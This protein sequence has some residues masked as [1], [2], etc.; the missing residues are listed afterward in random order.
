[1]RLLLDI[2]AHGFGHLSQTALI[3]SALRR[4]RPNLSLVVRSGLDPQILAARLGPSIE[5]WPSDTDFG[6]VM[7]GP[8][9]VDR[10][11]TF[12]RY[13]EL[14][15][16]LDRVVDGIAKGLQRH[17]IDAVFS[18][19]SFPVLI[20]ARQCGTPSVACSSLIWSEM[21]EFYFQGIA[22]SKPIVEGMR[23]AY[24]TATGLV[25][26]TPGMPMSGHQPARVQQPIGRRGRNRRGELI[27][28][29]GGDAAT[30]VLLWAFGGMQ[31]N[32]PPYLRAV[33]N[34]LS[35][36][37]SSWGDSVISADGLGWP[38][39]DLIASCD[40]VI[41]KPG[42]GI[43]VELGANAKPN[44]LLS[45]GDWPEEPHLIEWLKKVAPCRLVSSSE[46]VDA[47]SFSQMISEVLAEPTKSPAAVGG[48][49][50][51]VDL[52]RQF[53]AI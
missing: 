2:T 28:R 33:S 37:P 21:A 20:A 25:A 42:Y 1:M 52:C 30:R 15:D 14:F 23:A 40:V 19:I 46:N 43:V 53:W 50:Q 35:L 39:E 27:S 13:Q 7:D 51:V 29:L 47:S 31:P 45:R 26:L 3:I 18:N 22:D 44:I 32:P 34:T 16:R 5:T 17:S 6:C 41:S 24:D 8:F 11:R 12:F 38:F 4:R 9:R 10:Q 36:G 49:D 48:E